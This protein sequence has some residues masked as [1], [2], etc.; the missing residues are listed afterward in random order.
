M[1]Q[2]CEGRAPS[3]EA[4]PV[5]AV[6]VDHG[7]ATTAV[8][9]HLEMRAVSGL[10][11][12]L[13]PPGEL[14]LARE[15]LSP[16][17]YRVL[18]SA[19]GDAYLWRDRLALADQE[20]DDYFASPN[21]QLWMLRVAGEVAGYFEFQRHDDG[22]VE[23]M[24]FGLVARYFGRGLGGWMLTRAVEEAFAL[25]A[26]RLTLHTCTLDSPRAL[27]NYLARGFVITREEVYEVEPPR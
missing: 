16:Q 27:P 19:V 15:R 3:H 23:I 20:L 10:R 13:M 5:A 14:T 25:G 11:P 21:V 1:W 12:A 26:T 2:S 22:R 8:R 4:P 24:Y 18:Y 7:G 6:S 9:T 17:E